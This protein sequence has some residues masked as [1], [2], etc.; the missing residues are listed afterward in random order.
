MIEWYIEQSLQEL[1]IMKRYCGHRLLVQS[2]A[3][4]LEDESRLTEVKTRIYVPVARQFCCKPSNVER[5]IRTV[6]KRAWEEFPD[7]LR[8]MARY[9]LSGPPSPS[10][11]IEIIMNHVQRTYL[12]PEALL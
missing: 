5:N 7:A 11:L 3:L 1:H 8:Q 9:D 4:A 12:S 6:A 2:V 10:E